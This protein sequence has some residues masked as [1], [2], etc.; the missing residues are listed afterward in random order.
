MPLNTLAL[1][2]YWS[3]LHPS[4]DKWNTCRIDCRLFTERMI[5]FYC[6]PFIC[7]LRNGRFSHPSHKNSIYTSKF[8]LSFPFDDLST[9]IR[10]SYN[11]IFKRLLRN[12][13]STLIGSMSVTFDAQICILR[14]F[15]WRPDFIIVIY[16]R[17]WHCVRLLVS[18][19]RTISTVSRINLNYFGCESGDG[20][21]ICLLRKITRFDDKLSIRSTY[22]MEISCGAETK[23][24]SC[25]SVAN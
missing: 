7:Y 5:F 21:E 25:L 11:Q 10:P 6:Y 4:P 14:R 15:N 24:F 22:C 8:T 2:P 17:L 23:I 16:S 3:N 12:C 1:Q 19:K 9:P 18:N 13:I 20:N